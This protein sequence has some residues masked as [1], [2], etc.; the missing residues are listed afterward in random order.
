[1]AEHKKTRQSN[2]P[3]DFI[4]VYLEKLDTIKDAENSPFDGIEIINKVLE[5]NVHIFKQSLLIGCTEEQLLGIIFD[6]LVAGSETT[7]HT[8]GF[9][10][11]YMIFHPDVQ[12]K[13]QEEIDQTLQGRPPSF[14][15]KGKWVER[16]S[17][18]ICKFCYLSNF[19]RTFK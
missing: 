15:D 11:L 13:V 8:L 5:W 1:M 6:I 3:R 14:T 17:F 7:S 19:H 18:S 4:D 16:Q 12:R 9:A 2:A 10:L